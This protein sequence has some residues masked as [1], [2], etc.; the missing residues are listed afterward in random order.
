MRPTTESLVRDW[1]RDVVADIRYAR[2]HQRV[3][4]E[5]FGTSQFRA[6]WPVRHQV[7]VDRYGWP[8]GAPK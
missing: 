3:T 1:L 4:D 5:A 6:I 2:V 8:V 7:G